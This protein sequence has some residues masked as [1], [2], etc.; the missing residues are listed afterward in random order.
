MSVVKASWSD[1]SPE[2]DRCANLVMD[3]SFLA[4]ATARV[5][6]GM[7]RH[8]L[9]TVLH[10][11]EACQR[12]AAACIQACER[13]GALPSLQVCVRHSQQCAEACRALIE[14]LHAHRTG[15][16]KRES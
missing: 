6:N 16:S 13:H 9:E 11:V 7:D 2:M 8:D 14:R 1:S 5:L 15:R 10:V 12:A 4:G 3:C